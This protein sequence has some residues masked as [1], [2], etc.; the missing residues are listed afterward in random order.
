MFMKSGGWLLSHAYH[1]GRVGQSQEGK[2]TI[3][4]IQQSNIG[5][6]RHGRVKQIQLDSEELPKLLRLCPGCCPHA[7]LASGSPRRNGT[8]G[9]STE[10]HTRKGFHKTMG[11]SSHIEN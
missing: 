7:C 2:Q 10:T 3:Y 8:I 1:R 11:G 5:Y 9:N 4:N 6:N